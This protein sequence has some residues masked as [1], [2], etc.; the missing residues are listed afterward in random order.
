MSWVKYGCITDCVKHPKGCIN[1]DLYKAM[2]DAIVDDGYL[3]LGYNTVNIDDCWSLK[4]GRDPQTNRLLADPDRFPSGMSALVKYAH[5]KNVMLGSYSDIGTKTCGGYP[6]TRSVN[7]SVDFTK[8]DAQTFSDWGVDSLKMDGCWVSNGRKNYR[9]M[10][11]E[12]S[13]ALSEQSNFKNLFFFIFNFK[14]FVEH[15]IVFAC[16]WPAYINDQNLN[17]SEYE[18]IKK[19][20][21]YWRNYG[22]I[23]DSWSSVLG[24][25]E[26]YRKYWSLISK[27]H[28]PGGWFDP[29]MLVIGNKGLNLEQSKAQMAFWCLW[30]APL[31]MSNDLRAIKP[32][33]KA[34][35][36]NKH[37]IAVDQD[38]LGRMGENVILD[39]KKQVWLKTLSDNSNRLSWAVLYFNS[40]H[41]GVRM[42]Y[43]LSSVL[44]QVNHDCKY[45]IYD[46]FEDARKIDTLTSEQNLTLAVKATGV[47][48]LKVIYV[49]N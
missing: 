26:H 34:V 30:S 38:P 49:Q 17:D 14:T 8:L 29:D 1:E 3:D 31:L 37:L 20:C 21:N 41:T 10:Y 33:F 28:G 27:H 12:F 7:G 15:K 23:S 22:D 19:N 43:K 9:I 6:G 4:L 24:I 16:S 35:L 11:P 39:G 25:I 5:D 40:G 42:S 46:L 48:F 36:Q 13:E 47:A 45:E 2:I 32:E 44:H 18:L